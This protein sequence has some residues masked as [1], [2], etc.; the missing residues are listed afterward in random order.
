MTDQTQSAVEAMARAEYATHGH[1]PECNS[2]TPWEDAD[3]DMKAAYL[4]DAE[5]NLAALISH[6][7]E[8]GWQI[9]PVVAT[10]EMCRAWENSTSGGVDFENMTD[11][12]V[13]NIIASLDYAAMLAAAPNPLEDE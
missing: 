4:E 13:N 10:E 8:S 11:N 1:D 6:L 5:I 3:Q 9:V 7:T 12:E 2:D